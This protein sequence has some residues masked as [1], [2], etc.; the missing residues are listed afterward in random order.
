MNRIIIT[1][2]AIILLASCGKKN[3]KPYSYWKVNGVE[4]KSNNVIT[5]R[6]P[7]ATISSISSKDKIRFGISFNLP[8]FPKAGEFTINYENHNPNTV[9]CVFYFDTIAYVPKE[10]NKGKLY[11]FEQKGK[12]QFTLPQAWFV[13]YNSPLDSVLIEGTFY[14][15]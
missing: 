9:S 12:A 2:V 15:P 11:A 13:K 10:G 5:S 6:I 8:N 7:K 3:R 1:A 14:E 4:Y